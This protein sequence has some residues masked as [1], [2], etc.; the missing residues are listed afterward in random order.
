MPGLPPNPTR[1]QIV[2]LKAVAGSGG[3]GL[4]AVDGAGEGRGSGYSPGYSPD[5]NSMI[6]GGWEASPTGFEPSG[7]DQPGSSKPAD[8]INDNNNLQATA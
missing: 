2:Q 5:P 3:A 6:S 4:L 1:A 8:L 7:R